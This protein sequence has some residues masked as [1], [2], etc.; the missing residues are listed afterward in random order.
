MEANE[1][2]VFE[3][4]VAR[5]MLIELRWDGA[6]ACVRCKS[7]EVADVRSRSI[8]RCKLCGKQFSVTSGTAFNSHKLSH[9]AIVRAMML[10]EGTGG[11]YSTGGLAKLLEVTY[12]SAMVLK[13]KMMEAYMD[14]DGILASPSYISRWYWQGF[15]LFRV[16]GATVVRENKHGECRLAFPEKDA[17]LRI[18]AGNETGEAC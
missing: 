3:E 9:S 15:N 6:P 11:E 14:Q 10:H 5:A 17:A 4:A 18:R 2:P 12:K 1:I 7:E 16:Q 8:F 13:R